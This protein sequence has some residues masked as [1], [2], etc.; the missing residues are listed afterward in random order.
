MNLHVL[1]Y[2]NSFW[3]NYFHGHLIAS[4]KL[5]YF[6]VAEGKIVVGISNKLIHSGSIFVV[7]LI[8]VFPLGTFDHYD[9]PTVVDGKYS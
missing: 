6:G 1:I 9:R 3:F 4:F 7:N 8:G 5:F 2:L